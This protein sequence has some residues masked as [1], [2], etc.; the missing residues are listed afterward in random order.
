LNVLKVHKYCL[1]KTGY[2]TKEGFGFDHHSTFK[3]Y[4]K[5][6]CLFIMNEEITFH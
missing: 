5:N 3:N 4:L 2:E 6:T 1:F